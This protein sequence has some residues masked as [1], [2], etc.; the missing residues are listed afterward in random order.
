[1]LP[2][3]KTAIVLHFCQGSS[4]ISLRYA[5]IKMNKNLV[6]NNSIV[7]EKVMGREI[8]DSRGNPTVEAMVYLS[9][10]SVGKAAVPSG[11][12]TGIYE[13][14]ELRDKDER[15]MGKGVTKAVNNI[16]E[17]LEKAIV[18]RSPFNQLVID[19]LLIEADGTENK[20]KLGANAILAVS[21]AVSRAAAESL[22]MPYYAYVGGISGNTMP[23]PM[24]NILNGGAH[25]KN[26]ID[27]QEFMI[28]PLGASSFGAGLRM[29]CE[30]YHH[31]AG[32]LE[33][34]G[35]STA[36]GDEGGFAPDLSGEE[37]A[38]EIILQAIEK[39]GYTY[40]RDKDFM[41]S[42]DVAASEWKDPENGSGFY[43]LP[44]QNKQYNRT[45]LIE[46]WTE[47][48][49]KYPIYSIEDPLDED[50]IE[51]W[52]RLTNQIGDKVILVGDDLFVTNPSRL[53]QGILEGYANAILI[54][55]NQIGTLS[56]TIEAIKMAKAGGYKTIMSHR[57]GETEDT[58]IADL[59]VALNTGHIKTGAPCRAERTAKYNR[60]LRIEEEI[61]NFS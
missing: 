16:N 58:T 18:N 24:M 8:I 38:I 50:D 39:A 59:S 6:C 34:K 27:C 23:V 41:I 2:E 28:L 43:I 37:E 48:I 53:R 45:E 17:V 32:I 61:K 44:K 3:A 29:C 19:K 56:E 47:L 14:V 11:A 33:E 49:E 36:V 4:Q 51:G 25:S 1:M 15:Y 42:L 22:N 60:L 46:K 31:L 20:G 5:G 9:D 26:S 12:S 10:G 13:A 35:L 55:P 30:V 52:V 40:G 54:K 7:I 57:S 21:L